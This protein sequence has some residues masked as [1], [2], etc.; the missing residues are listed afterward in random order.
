MKQASKYLG[1]IISG[2]FV[3]LIVPYSI[4]E[5]FDD[6]LPFSPVLYLFSA[7]SI[8]LLAYNIYIYRRDN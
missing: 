7:V 2:L 1:L 3:L 5:W 6:R 8:I 4:M